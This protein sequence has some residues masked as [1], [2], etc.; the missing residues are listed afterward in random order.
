[1]LRFPHYEWN[2]QEQ[3]T[4]MELTGAENNNGTYRSRKQQ[5][6]LQEQKT[7]MELTGAENNNGTL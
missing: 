7:T 5:W 6:N 4:T 1:M 2:L 3:K